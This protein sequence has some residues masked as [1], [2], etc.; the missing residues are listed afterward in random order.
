[1]GVQRTVAII[2]VV[3]AVVTAGVVWLVVGNAE[4]RSRHNTEIIE[5]VRV[6]SA[7]PR[8]TPAAEVAN[9]GTEVAGVPRQAAPTG[10][11]RSLDDLGGLVAAF[12][13]PEGTVVASGMFVAPAELA[14]GMADRLATPG[15]T[16]LAV[17]VDATRA[18]GGWL[19][20]G[21][22]VNVLAPSVCADEGALATAAAGVAGAEVRCRRAR[23]LYHA[24]EVLAVG[25]DAAP[26]AG[27]PGA[28]GGAGE[29]GQV[30]AAGAVTVVLSLPPRAAQWVASYDNDLILTLVRPDYVPG[31]VPALPGIVERLPGE[32]PDLLTP[33]CDEPGVPGGAGPG[34][35]TPPVPPGVTPPCPGVDPP[36]GAR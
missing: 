10:A 27:A 7:V 1:M 22:R 35:R 11:L 28:P 17:S 32:E 33:Y 16:A 3:A 31:A 8:G 14:G 36:G 12:D 18:V 20:P 19:R 25:T 5:V 23:Y 26:I 6:T 30:P 24:A 21:D 9:G 15:R 2:A 34:G 13:I 29:A 4:Q